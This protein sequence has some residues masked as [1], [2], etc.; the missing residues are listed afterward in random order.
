MARRSYTGLLVLLVGLAVIMSGYLGWQRH[1]VE[2]ENRQLD[3]IV[4]YA[5]VVRLAERLGLEPVDVLRR[6]QAAGAT[7]ALFKEQV[8]GDLENRQLWTRS[9]EELLADPAMAR[10]ARQIKPG[11][12]YLLTRQPELAQ[13]VAKN[14]EI[15][16]LPGRVQ[17]LEAANL[18]LVGVPL[19]KGEIAGIGLGFAPEEL[20]MVVK[21][22][23]RL[24]LQ[25]RSWSPVWP[26]SIE[27][28]IESLLPYQPNMS[29]LLFNDGV[30]PGHPVQTPELAQ[31]VKR[32]GV[33]VGLIEFFNQKGLD[34][35]AL[36]VDKNAVRLHTIPQREMAVMSQ[37]RAVD[38]FVLAATE[39]N[40]RVLFVR[41]FFKG[42]P[43]FWLN[44]NTSFLSA[45]RRELAAKGFSFGPPAPFGSVPGSRLF[46]LVIGLGVLAGGVLLAQSI[47]LGA[48]GTLLGLLGAVTWAGLLALGY[49]TEGRQMMAFLAA[50]IFPTLA[51]V[52]G[53][54]GRA[55][56]PAGA[57][58][59]LLIMTIITL[60]GALLVVGL[61]ADRSFLLKIHQF[62]GVKAAHLAPLALMAFFLAA[63]PLRDR[64]RQGIRDFLEMPISV[65]HLLLAGVAIALVI[66]YVTRTGNE[67]G[68]LVTGLE[69]KM[70]RF[71][72]IALVVRPR[73]KEFLI[74]HPAMLMALFLGYRHRRMPL[75]L[76]GG[77]GQV[78]LLNTFTHLHT[79]LGVSLLRTVNGLWVG[80]LIG[81]VLILLYRRVYRL[82]DYNNSGRYRK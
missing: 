8:L 82:W 14:L 5:E 33:P 45:L 60:T 27:A 3:L 44:A 25:V 31:E 53:M 58:V 34:Q 6:L 70:R 4:E 36:A 21:E 11:S 56:T 51:V 30:I 59:L 50:V 41:L 22:G 69:Q 32:L 42:D 66:V 28:V 74:G 24:A 20:E 1:L 64:W 73:T 16:V 75:A 43:D 10:V 47:G 52:L 61:L 67:G 81:L 79:P 76:V 62:L 54:R 38:R 46:L 65:K 55:G 78:S 77:I 71:L 48:L 80:V 2:R 49:T 68:A 72:D 23:L 57:V 15:K 26:G 35:L 18:F 9:G 40:M 37:T 63:W 13:R 29:V 39:R 12:L 19:P 7:G 17:V